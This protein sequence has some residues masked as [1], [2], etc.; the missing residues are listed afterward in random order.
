MKL[1]VKIASALFGVIAVVG[2]SFG[3][4]EVLSPRAA[5]AAVLTYTVTGT[6]GSSV[7]V[8][9]NAP[10]V[11]GSDV[12]VVTLPASGSWSISEPANGSY[13][14]FVSAVRVGVM[15]YNAQPGMTCS[16]S[17]SAN[18]TDNEPNEYYCQARA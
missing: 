18:A 6:P 12:A 4:T 14:P 5:T 7:S 11:R 13:T 10:G 15:A 1:S 8:A 9:W 3:L 2:V 17:G 16:I